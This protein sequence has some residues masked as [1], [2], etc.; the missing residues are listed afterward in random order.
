MN[1]RIKQ[2][3][4]KLE[5]PCRGVADKR[6]KTIPGASAKRQ[7]II[8]TLITRQYSAIHVLPN[9]YW[10]AKYIPLNNTYYIEL[11]AF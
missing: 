6:Q 4:S 9:L 3:R 1:T 2:F 7:S 11:L 5:C 8:N 10:L